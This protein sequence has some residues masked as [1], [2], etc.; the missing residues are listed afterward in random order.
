MN[1]AGSHNHS[2]SNAGSHNHSIGSSGGSE[3]RPRNIALMYC[4][5]F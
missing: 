1:S 2:M 5:K 4:I 3:T